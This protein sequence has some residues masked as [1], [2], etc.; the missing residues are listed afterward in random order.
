M[1]R[2]CGDKVMSQKINLLTFQ[3][4][5]FPHGKSHHLTAYTH[6]HLLSIATLPNAS[7]ALN[8]R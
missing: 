7:R 2:S 4:N 1:I 3:K 8:A 5:L 6:I